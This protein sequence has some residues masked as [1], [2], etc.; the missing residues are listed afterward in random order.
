MNSEKKRQKKWVAC[1]IE[2][3]Y[4]GN[5]R[6]AHR[7]ERKLASQK[8]RSKYKKT[9]REKHEKQLAE[10]RNA[11]FSRDEL[12]KG[13]VISIVPQGILVASGDQEFLCTLRGVLKKERGLAKNLVTVG[14]FVLFEKTTP[15]EGL[16][17]HVEP[18]KTILSRADN[19][20]RRKEQLIAANI[21]Q[22]LITASV[23]SPPLKPSLID[24]YI[25]ATQKGGMTPIIVVNKID[26][27]STSDAEDPILE[28]EKAL[29]ETF[30]EGYRQAGLK[31][32]PVSTVTGEG[33]EAL[34][35]QMRDKSSVFS[36]QSGVGKS[37]LINALIGSD[38]RIGKIVHRTKKGAHTT[39]TTHLM[40]LDFGGWCIDTPGIKSFGVW[41][42][43]QNELESYFSEIYRVG[44]TCKFPNCS[45]LH[46]EDCAVIQAVEEGKISL[47]RFESYHDLLH[48]ITQKHL[49]R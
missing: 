46:E 17:A 48:S 2:D 9:D 13:R 41:D 36:G 19:L 15:E 6:K 34:K 29:F 47:L 22:V 18:R 45:H 37:S 30:L 1:P 23:L 12:D 40:P 21:D 43:D 38:L 14:D 25:I 28:Q 11:K 24:R 49:R 3:E 27:L 39:T 35:E 33:I 31:V 42:L 7:L 5:D 26:L 32:I 8:D 44:R 20:S 4:F 16:I 10:Q